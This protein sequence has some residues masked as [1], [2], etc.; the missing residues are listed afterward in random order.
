MDQMR[1]VR[2]MN[3]P[4][5][6]GNVQITASASMIGGC[7]MV[8]LTVR[9]VQMKIVRILTVPLD[10]GN[11]QTTASVLIVMFV[12]VSLVAMMAQMRNV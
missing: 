6:S 5:A 3:V 4:I 1:T 7:V 10:T 11:V 9:M 8:A 2:R 12:M